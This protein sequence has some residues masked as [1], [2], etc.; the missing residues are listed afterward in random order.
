MDNAKKVTNGVTTLSSHTE[1]YKKE[2]LYHKTKKGKTKPRHSLVPVSPLLFF[3]LFSS[4]SPSSSRILS[5]FPLQPETL[6]FFFYKQS[7]FLFSFLLGRMVA[8][9]LFSPV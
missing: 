8:F 6:F 4:I 2:T 7:Q 3:P 9:L 5:S 1:T